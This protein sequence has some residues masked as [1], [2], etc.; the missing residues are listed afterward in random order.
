[1]NTL[2]WIAVVL[3]ASVGMAVVL[4]AMAGRLAWT[5]DKAQAVAAV[6]LV[7]YVIAIISVVALVFVA[8]GHVK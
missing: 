8:L 2:Q 1:M 5:S 7:F 6:A 4:G 3:F